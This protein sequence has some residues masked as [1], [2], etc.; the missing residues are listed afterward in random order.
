[1]AF[2]SLMHGEDMTVGTE[3]HWTLTGK[4]LLVIALVVVIAFLVMSRR[5]TVAEKLYPVAAG[6]ELQGS[7]KQSIAIAD[8]AKQS[9]Q[10]STDML[11]EIALGRAGFAMPDQQE[12][13]IRALARRK[14]PKIG[15]MLATLLQPHEGLGTRMAAAETL[16]QLPCKLECV[17]SVLHYLERVYQ[18]EPNSED[19]FTASPEVAV[20]LATE[21][22]QFYH[23]LDDVLETEKVNTLA[24]LTDVY[25]LG[26]EDP[27][28]FG[29]D[30]V[31]R[32]RLSDACP[33]LLQSQRQLENSDNDAD[34]FKRF[35]PRT[36]P[37]YSTCVTPTSSGRFRFIHPMLPTKHLFGHDRP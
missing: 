23:D 4:V 5:R 7:D 28:S 14:D 33:L 6:Y 10:Q 25:G 2:D 9:D 15:A 19:G 11:L 18:D 13:A 3:R 37:S 21:R 31:S 12:Q 29:L 22:Q 26:S 1:M 16:K 24:V 32:L 17:A 30:V 20:K 36:H 34:R 35:C 27:S 8:L